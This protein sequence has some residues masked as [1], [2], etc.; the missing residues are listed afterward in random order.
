MRTC[1]AIDA[2]VCSGS[3][4]PYGGPS[5]VLFPTSTGGRGRSIVAGLVLAAGLLSAVVLRADTV[6]G[7]V[8][9][10]GEPVTGFRAVAFVKVEQGFKTDLKPCVKTT[11]TVSVGAE[12]LDAQGDYSITFTRPVRDEDAC[13]FA[14]NGV[15]VEVRA[16]AGGS[17]L[18]RS[19]TKTFPLT[20]TTF[21]F[22]HNIACPPPPPPGGDPM[23]VSG[24]LLLCGQPAA[25]FQV[26]AM[27]EVRTGVD[28]SE[29]GGKPCELSNPKYA[30][31]G[32]TTAGSDGSFSI[33]FDRPINLDP[34]FT[35]AF[36]A[37]VSIRLFDPGTGGLV[38]F[39]AAKP[40]AT[41]VVFDQDIC[42][43]FVAVS[44]KVIL[45]SA[46]RRPAEGDFTTDAQIERAI[47]QANT[48]LA[49]NDVGWRL[50]L[51]EIVNVPQPQY[52]KIT[53]SRQLRDLERDAQADADGFS[54]RLDAI[55]IYVVDGITLDGFGGAGGV[56][57]FPPGS[58]IIAINNR[59]ILS[60]GV[61]WLHEIG[62]FLSLLHTFDCLDAECDE[63]VC[64][65]RAAMHDGFLTHAVLC[66]GNCPHDENVM[67][68]NSVDVSDAKFSACQIGEMNFELFDPSG[69]RE[70]VLRRVLPTGMVLPRVLPELPAFLRGDSNSSG[71]VD[72]SDGLNTLGVLILG[73]G[74]IAC[75][76]AADANDDGE[77]DISDA[78]A[79]WSTLFLGSDVIAT[80]GPANCSPD[81]TDDALE[82]CGYDEGGCPV[83]VGRS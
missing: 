3:R 31:G 14:L 9:N 48:V 65:G 60:A 41:S 16:V 61:G 51:D 7:R 56:C 22:N 73:T 32:T 28:M 71:E 43:L 21:T 69:S 46:G 13:S 12:L 54:W 62:H 55:N 67:S 50:F 72:I 11:S 6:R 39:S 23:T 44:V 78:V 36:Q 26:R 68:Y 38:W 2:D 20:N 57:S 53:T 76:D 24:K 45:N 17:L 29:F 33:K 64:T 15:F 74:E 47:S 5:R 30:V 8:T 35:C 77:V 1:P 58:E 4:A 42:R 49:T 70:H 75:P 19:P 80:P 81:E 34:E 18:F 37:K 59:G 10:C 40:I 25:G 79:T 27:T 83:S 82:M 52:F 63:D 66:P